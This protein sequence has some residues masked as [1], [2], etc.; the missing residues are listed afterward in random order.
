MLLQGLQVPNPSLVSAQLLLP[1]QLLPR[2]H[3]P[4]RPDPGVTILVDNEPLPLP[5]PRSETSASIDAG[6]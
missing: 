5:L 4:P 2:A 6:N 1:T 3:I